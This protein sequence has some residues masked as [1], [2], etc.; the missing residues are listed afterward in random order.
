MEILG[1]RPVWSMSDSEQLSALD[2]VFAEIA[3]LKTLAL[4]LIAAIDQSGYATELGAG[5]TARLLTKRYRID[6]SEA[7]RDVRLATSLTKYAA[8]TAALPDPTIPFTNPTTG[9]TGDVG[10]AGDAGDSDA[11]GGTWRVDPAQAAA[12]VSVLDKVPAAVPTENLEFAEQKL[13]DLAATHTPTELRKAGK[14]IRDILDP[15]GPEPDEKAAYL[16]ESL[17]WK[18]ADQGV[19]FRGYLANENAE[20]F[21]TLIHAHAKPHKTIE[22]DLDPRP[23]TKRQADALTTILNTATATN[24]TT[25]THPKPADTGDTSDPATDSASDSAAKRTEHGEG[26]T[27]IQLPLPPADTDD[28]DADSRDPEA[29]TADPPGNDRHFVPGHGPKPHISITIDYNDLAAATAHATGALVFGDNLSAATIRRLACD[30]EV[31]PIVLGSK[32]Q[33][34]DVGTTQ[35]LVTRPMRRALNA[36]DKGC[37]ICNAPPIHCDAHHVVPWLDG[38]IT[39]VSNLALLCKRD[40]RDLHS[41]HWQIRILNGI[42]HVTHPT[43][44]TPDQ[45]PRNKYHPPT[46]DIIHHP[47]PPPPNPW[48]DDEHLPDKDEVPPR[49]RARPVKPSLFNPWGDEGSDTDKSRPPTPSDQATHVA[50][51]PWADGDAAHAATAEQPTLNGSQ[52][53]APF[54]PWSDDDA[55]EPATAGPPTPS[56]RA[57]RVAFDPWGDG[58]AAHASTAGP[59]TP[60]R[61]SGCMPFDSWADNASAS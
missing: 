56:H 46:A 52:E 57:K 60:A 4:Q 49:T 54:N 36:R 47:K 26:G 39:A 19:T 27:L 35:R 12:I 9:D 40:H 17:A 30:A 33:P 18:T 25:V 37:V 13:I 32:S 53:T 1:E 44:T 22:G 16:R 61:W 55:P 3:R 41:G 7:H 58:E 6:S 14:S 15:D 51:D 24:T 5:N 20:L 48:T 11:A 34:L 31:L 10:N 21:R 28:G 29:C 59:P 38:G 50:F 43:W 42:V 23:L 2:A 45:I 8:T